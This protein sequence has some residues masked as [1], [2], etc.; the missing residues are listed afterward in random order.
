MRWERIRSCRQTATCTAVSTT[1]YKN[2]IPCARLSLPTQIHDCSC[3]TAILMVT[4]AVA[5]SVSNWELAYQKVQPSKS[6]SAPCSRASCSFW[7]RLACQASDR[8]ITLP[9]QSSDR[10]R[11]FSLGAKVHICSHHSIIH[12]EY[13]PST[14]LI[15]CGSAFLKKAMLQALP[16]SVL[17]NILLMSVSVAPMV[18]YV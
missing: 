17:A 9:A 7:L 1:Q 3:V 12:P 11:L 4:S 10:G 18:G 15:A 6:L 8:S 2:T 5:A 16:G 14:L 13:Q